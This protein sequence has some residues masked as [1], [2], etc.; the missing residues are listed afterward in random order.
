MNRKTECLCFKCKNFKKGSNSE[1]FC[2]NFS[3][4]FENIEFQE[5]ICSKCKYHKE[6]KY[7]F[8]SYCYKGTEDNQKE[9]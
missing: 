7:K 1:L 9:L 3:E 4:I 5:C 8:N 6:K 2:D